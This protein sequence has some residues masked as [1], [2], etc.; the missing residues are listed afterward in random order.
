MSARISFINAHGLDVKTSRYVVTLHE[1]GNVDASS[2]HLKVAP[3]LNDLKARCYK[4]FLMYNSIYAELKSNNTARTTWNARRAF[5][6]FSI[7]KASSCEQAGDCSSG[8]GLSRQR[9]LAFSKAC[10]V[11]RWFWLMQTLQTGS[12]KM[13][14]VSWMRH[15]CANVLFVRLS[16]VS[17]VISGKVQC[18]QLGSDFFSFLLFSLTNPSPLCSTNLQ[19]NN[20]ELRVIPCVTHPHTD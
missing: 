20:L 2:S 11:S 5:W 9:W 19:F 7:L 12:P 17:W 6:H 8:A 3:K 13:P 10:K 1:K 4:I 15:L 18:I 16:P 14:P